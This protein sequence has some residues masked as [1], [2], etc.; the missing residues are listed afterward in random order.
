M[1][2]V[3]MLYFKILVYRMSSSSRKAESAGSSTTVQMSPEEALQLFEY[4]AFALFPDLPNGFEFGVDY[5][6]W[7]TGPKFKGIKMIPPGVHFIYVSSLGKHGDR[8]PRIGFFHNFAPKEILVKKWDKENEDLADENDVEQVERL[9]LNLKEMDQFLGPYPFENH[10]QWFSLSYLINESLINRLSP[11]N[12]KISSQCDLISK[13]SQDLSSGAQR[14]DRENPVRTRFRDAQLS[15]IELFQGLPIMNTSPESEIKFTTIPTVRSEN[16]S[17]EERTSKSMDRSFALRKMLSTYEEPKFLLGELQFAYICFLLGHVYE[18]FEQWKRLIDMICNCD[19]ALGEFDSFYSDFIMVL[20][21]QLK[22]TPSEFFV[23]IVAR[24]NFLTQSLSNFFSLVAS[25]E[26]VSEELKEKCRRF[27]LSVSA[28]FMWDFSEVRDEFAPLRNVIHVQINSE[29]FVL[30][31]VSVMMSIFFLKILLY[32]EG[33]FK[34]GASK[35]FQLVKHAPVCEFRRQI[36]LDHTASQ[37]AKTVVSFCN[38]PVRSLM[39]IANRTR[40]PSSAIARR[41]LWQRT[42][43]SISGSKPEISAAKPAAPEPSTINFS[44]SNNCNIATDMDVSETLTI[45][46]TKDWT[47]L[48]ALQPNVGTAKPSASVGRSV[49]V[50]GFPAFIDSL[51]V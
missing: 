50:V 29:N 17:P 38:P 21:F 24:N 35:Y 43:V 48:K 41:K 39:L 47:V 15:I 9:R 36:L 44:V 27:Q 33:S 5:N 31:S 8:A 18:A 25:S 28:H 14:V 2:A 23:D 51:K 7:S 30:F 11:T 42:V 6:A 4:G 3:L 49:T 40:R 20:H 22:T 16:F 12:G 45:L 37:L 46:S 26:T 32:Y 34:N 10:K 13:E 19:E 1:Y